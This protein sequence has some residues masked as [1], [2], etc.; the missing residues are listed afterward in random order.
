M[1]KLSNTQ[2]D[3]KER[4][5]SRY[6]KANN[7]A[8]GSSV[9]ANSNVTQKSLA[10][11]EAELYKEDT[12]QINR[13]II[14]SK[15][16]EMYG[17]RMANKY[18]SDLKNHYIYSHDETSLR[19]Y[20]ASVTMYP[21]L[22]EGTKCLGGIS[23]APK[24]LQSFCG[25]F[26][27][28]VYQVASDFAGAVATVEFLHYFDYF[29][30]K[31]YGSH[32]LETNLKEVAQELQGVMYALNQ[33]ASARG[34]QSVFW[35]IS[36]FDRDYMRE[37]FGSFYYP[38][39]TTVNFES[40]EK[41]QKYFMEW[42]KEERKKELLTFPVL[43]A[44]VLTNDSGFADEEFVDFL[45]NQMGSGHSFFVYMSDSVDSL[46]SCCRLRNELADNT[47]SYTLGAGGVVTGSAQVITIN[48]NRVV[49]SNVTLPTIHKRVQKYLLA[50]KEVYK[51]YIS[52]GLLPSYSAGFMDIDK[53]FLTVGV[54]GLVEAAE[55]L[56]YTVGNNDDYKK[57]A[58][59]VVGGL[60]KRNKAALKKTG[61]RFNTELVPAENLGVKNAKWDTEDGLM[62]TRACYN[63]YFYVVEDENS[64][65]LDKVALH[66]KDIT[67]YLDGG[68]ALHCNLQQLMSAS[69]AKQLFSICRIQGVPY[70]TFNVKCT[71]C[72]SCGTID[73]QTRNK[74]NSC[75]STDIDY[76]TRVIGYLK[77]V[78][79]FSS[80]RQTEEDRRFYM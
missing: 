54:N 22:L 16:K 35:N 9:D 7:A 62:V 37:M 49:Q 46:A 59:G 8:D 1:Y 40:L 6:I 34:N 57:W 21:F 19:P 64:T 30:R 55:F 15:L 79:N 38:D 43:T 56:G 63:S 77:R 45:C 47:F 5:I 72:N 18:L 44:S 12:I 66:G 17:E 68:S 3:S 78:S 29:A 51:E 10:T 26:V 33:P 75:G 74:C 31:E 39:S 61:V 36:V 42:F 60:K 52:A 27:N 65:L 48:L 53:Q 58:A 14:W 13:K 24:N 23:G 11:L 76:G 50:H 71:I 28:M 2:V 67:Q 25:S 20:C 41:L 80:A 32:Y 4:F 73:P 69:Q 70:F